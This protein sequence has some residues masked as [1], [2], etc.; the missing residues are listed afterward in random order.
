M[1]TTQRV[2]EGRRRVVERLKRSGSSTACQ[3]AGDLGITESAVRQHLDALAAVGLVEGKSLPPNGRG[4]PA[5]TWSLTEMARDLF[6]DRHAD[7]TVELLD[8]VSSELGADALD[9]VIAARERLQLARYRAAIPENGS[10][11]ERAEALARA[12]SAE[13]Y[14]AEVTGDGDRLEL[15][16]H[17]CPICE[18]A[19]TC[20]NFCRSELA[21]FEKVLGP[22]VRVER[23]RHLLS[24][25][26]R[27]SYTIERRG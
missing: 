12:R 22:D 5:T 18:A 11:A 25:D 24:G 3:L 6:P 8:A 9:A 13:G 27:C 23:T 17:H 20:R 15:V 21:I 16:E 2:P 19:A 7:L 4:R 1:A 10:V 26:E 14:M